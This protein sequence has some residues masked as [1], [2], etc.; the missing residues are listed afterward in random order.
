[1]SDKYIPNSYQ[2]P[3]AIVD[4]LASVLSDKAFKVYHVIVRKT[5]GWCKERDKISV[6]Q[7]MTITNTKKRNTI[8]RVIQEYPMYEYQFLNNTNSTIY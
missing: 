8:Y 2:T 5:L 4:N 3:N 1:M 6:T 7:I